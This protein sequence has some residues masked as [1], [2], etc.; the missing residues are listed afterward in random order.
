MNAFQPYDGDAE[1]SVLGAMM[2]DKEAMWWALRHMSPED[3]SYPKCQNMFRLIDHQARLEQPVDDPVALATVARELEMDI[4]VV[5]VAKLLAFVTTGK[6]ITVHGKIVKDWAD[7]R[8]TDEFLGN[9]REALRSATEAPEGL[10]ASMLQFATEMDSTASG[11][12]LTPMEAAGAA[13]ESHIE[14]REQKKGIVGVT[15]GIDTLNGSTA[16]FRKGS[17]YVLAGR[18]GM[19]KTA[20]ALSMARCA[21]KQEQRRVVIFSLEMSTVELTQRWMAMESDVSLPMVASGREETFGG[22]NFVTAEQ[23]EAIAQASA[24]IANWDFIVDDDP[25]VTVTDIRTRLWRWHHQKPIDLVIVDYM[26]LMGSDDP[27]A[28]E[29]KRVSDASRQLKL[30]ARSFDIPV[31]ALAQLNR[32]CENRPDKKPQLSDLRSSGTIEQDADAVMLLYRPGHYQLPGLP[33][34]YTEII[35]AKHRRGPTG[36]ARCNWHK[37]TA[38]YGN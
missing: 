9:Q 35:L 31:L 32:E 19:G 5:D 8:Q 13:L 16:G 15:T 7:V 30:L 3:F 4:T 38:R 17:L 26:Q 37:E 33:E 36:I 25:H 23:T 29:Y 1:S 20:A 18:P 11:E 14:V 24:Q 10:R 27:K 21:I 6:N 2:I 12:P 34:N 22:Y 28:E